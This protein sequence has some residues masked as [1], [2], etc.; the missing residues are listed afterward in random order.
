MKKLGNKLKTVSL[1]AFTLLESVTCL[2]VTCLMISLMSHSVTGIYQSIE[3]HLFFINF[4][5]FYRHSQ[6]L[7]VLNQEESYLVFSKH[8]IHCG[9]RKLEIPPQIRLL[10]QD[11]IRLNKQGGNHS[12]ATIAFQTKQARL[13]YKLNLGSGTYQ[14]TKS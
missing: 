12:L 11:K 9:Q 6:K 10:Y 2:W 4:E 13:I 8:T 5:N 7:C 3:S 1:E 14:K